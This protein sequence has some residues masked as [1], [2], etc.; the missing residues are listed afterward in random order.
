[1]TAGTIMPVD[2]QGGARYVGPIEIG[3]NFY[4]L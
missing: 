2:K 4:I 1:M 3:V